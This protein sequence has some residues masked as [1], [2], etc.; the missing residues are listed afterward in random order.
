VSDSAQ[1]T[2]LLQ[3]WQDG[4]DNAQEQLFHLV[5]RD[6]RRIAANRLKNEMRPNTLQATD[7]VHEIYPQLARQRKLWK[8]RGQF[9]AI[10]SECMRRHLVDHARARTREK[11]GGEAVRVS[12]ADLKP[13]EICRIDEDDEI[14]AV[15]R[16]LTKLSEIDETAALVIKHRYFG[17]MK[18]EEI[19]EI[20]EVSP[21]TVD[22]TYRFARAWLQRELTFEFSPYLLSDGQIL[23]KPGFVREL[24]PESRNPLS[25]EWHRSFS[26]DLQTKIAGVDGK[27]V[28]PRLLREIITEINKALL[29]KLFTARSAADD[30]SDEKTELMPEDQIT[31]NRRMLE[32]AFAGKIL[33]LT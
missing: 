19:A 5:H 9:F 20:L 3:S 30:L 27:E 4:D 29:G 21:S 33:K 1:I 32:Q 14:L 8:N 11:R 22:R 16:S 7:L 31:S 17:G 13:T 15:D 25:L 23:D 10:A 26:K 18:R 28:D 24:R 12:F 2:T 6:L